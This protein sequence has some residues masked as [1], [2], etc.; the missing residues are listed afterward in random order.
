MGLLTQND[1]KL[2]RCY[3]DEMCKL[4][5]QSVEYQYI[6]ERDMTIHSEDNNKYSM[7]IRINILFDENP[8]V[9]TLNRLGWLTELQNQN[10]IIANLS[11]NT[12]NL[13]V[14]ARIRVQSISGVNRPRLFKITKIQSDLEYP[15]S[16]VCALVP[17]FDQY[18]QEN[19]YTLVNHEKIE[20]SS[21]ERTSKDQ[22]HEYITTDHNIDTTPEEYK[23]WKNEYNFIDENNSPYSG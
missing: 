15:D 12:P 23:E 4:I 22:P 10:P 18:P 14:G 19:R 21:S 6:T 8:S 9:N 17:V 20:Q 13:T 2:H 5:G 7:P 3:F 11:Y 16:Y 1:A